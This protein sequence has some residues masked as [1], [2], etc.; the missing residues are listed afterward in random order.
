MEIQIHDPS[1]VQPN[2]SR[3]IFFNGSVNSSSM[4]Q[5]TNHVITIS[6]QDENKRKIE[7]AQGR[8]Y[9]PEPIRLFIDS[10]GGELLSCFGVCSVLMASRT[11]VHTYVT[12]SALSAAFL[13]TICG[14]KRFCFPH[15]TLMYHQLSFGV[16]GSAKEVEDEHVNSKQVQKHMEQL[17]RERT[18]ITKE[19]LKEVYQKNEDW[20]FTPKQAKQY[21]VIDQIVTSI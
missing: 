14:D 16:Y 6:T 7:E 3:D 17:V 19:K 2:Q 21:K 1:S 11:P 4:G 5:I 8:E 18:G 9:T 20:Y 15:S 12:G 10:N 13:I